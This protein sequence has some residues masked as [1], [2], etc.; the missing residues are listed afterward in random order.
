M[1]K[2]EPE[3]VKLKKRKRRPRNAAGERNYNCG[4]GKSY[5]SYPALYTH[6]KNK[7]NGVFP[8]GSNAKRKVPRDSDVESE[9]LFIRNIDKF[10]KEFKNLLIHIDRASSMS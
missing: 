6:V 3:T 10:Y 9:V 7:H 1:E 5:L 2:G 4:C 8:I